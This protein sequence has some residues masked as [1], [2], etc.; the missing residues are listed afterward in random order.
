MQ[1]C[2]V[3]FP[4]ALGLLFSALA[5]PARAQEVQNPMPALRPL[6]GLEWRLPKKFAT[7]DGDRLVVDIPAE[8]VLSDACATARLPAAMLS[9]AGGFFHLVAHLSVS[10]YGDFHG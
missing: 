10:D 2:T 8:A 4:I 5:P 9:G 1:L 3:Q 6:S 7:L